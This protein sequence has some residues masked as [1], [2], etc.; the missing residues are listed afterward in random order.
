MYID[1]KAIGG[2]QIS[3]DGFLVSTIRVYY[4]AEAFSM[5]FS[6]ASNRTSEVYL[7]SVE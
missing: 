4:S 1:K 5:E 6:M 3:A 2:K 7:L